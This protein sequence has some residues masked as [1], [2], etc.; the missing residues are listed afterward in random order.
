MKRK[1]L[2][3]LIVI[4]SSCVK[5]NPTIPLE[6]TFLLDYAGYCS[7]NQ[8]GQ[9]IKPIFYAKN[10]NGRI[11]ISIDQ[12][13]TGDNSPYR[14]IG[15]SIL[16]IPARE[17]QVNLND[18]STFI[19]LITYKYGDDLIDANYKIIPSTDNYVNITELT[20]KSVKGFF[21]LSFERDTS[22]R[23]NHTAFMGNTVVYENG[24]FD[25]VLQ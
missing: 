12:Y 24:F 10:E 4:L 16:H 8:N 21:W 11:S 5:Q 22:I 13:W 3:I 15:L 1:N 17:G 25:A 23:K 14:N 6:E 2:L 9:E 20:D 18:D 7:L 19:G